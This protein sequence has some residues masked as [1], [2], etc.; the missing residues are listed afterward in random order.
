MILNDYNKYPLTI[1]ENTRILET[2]GRVAISK[3]QCSHSWNLQMLIQLYLHFIVQDFFQSSHW[4]S[5]WLRLDV[6]LLTLPRILSFLLDCPSWLWTLQ[7]E[8][9]QISQWLLWPT[10]PIDALQWLVSVESVAYLT[11]CRT[12]R[13]ARAPT[14]SN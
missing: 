2:C 8:N 11:S 6:H 4:H 10:F 7:I 14:L 13:K 3:I 1:I 5:L 12:H 9:C